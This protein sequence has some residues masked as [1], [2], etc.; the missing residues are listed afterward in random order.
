MTTNPNVKTVF[1]QARTHL[2]YGL[3]TLPCRQTDGCDCGGGYVAISIN[4]PNF[5]DVLIVP[6]SEIDGFVADIERMRAE[7]LGQIA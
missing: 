4:P 5:P 2:E 7:L 6:L 3:S 1:L